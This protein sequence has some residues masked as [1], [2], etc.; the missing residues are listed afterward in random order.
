M[1]VSGVL[2]IPWIR[3]TYLHISE[4][5][6]NHIQPVWSTVTR[7]T[8][9]KTEH[10]PWGPLLQGLQISKQN[11]PRGVHCYKAYRY[12]NRTH[13]MGSSV[14]RPRDNKYSY[15]KFCEIFGTNIFLFF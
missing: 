4:T 14:I 9:I 11:T 2:P 7:P 12:Q 3:N 5:D 8:D 13:P 15:L 1:Q 10:T 6:R